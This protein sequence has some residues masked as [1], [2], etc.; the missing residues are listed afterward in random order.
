MLLHRHVELERSNRGDC[1]E[2]FIL[3][4]SGL[5]GH[6]LE[7]ASTVPR[8]QIGRQLQ[9]VLTKWSGV[10]VAF[11]ALSRGLVVHRHRH[12]PRDLRQRD[13]F[14]GWCHSGRLGYDVVGRG[15]TN[16]AA[17][18]ISTARKRP[19][20][21]ENKNSV[22]MCVSHTSSSASG[23][24]D[25]ARTLFAR[26]GASVIREPLTRSLR[27]AHATVERRSP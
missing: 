13:A 2:Y 21:R 12:Q 16:R 10:H 17:G 22:A 15:R 1:A 3:S 4:A 14:I 19:E 27:F 24:V 25:E 26:G 6:A 9:L 23:A 20:Q 5:R 7:Q 18:W 11:E 8:P